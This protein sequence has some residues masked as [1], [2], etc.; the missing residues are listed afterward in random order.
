MTLPDSEARPKIAVAESQDIKEKIYR[1]RYAVYVDEMSKRP[2]YADHSRKFLSDALDES[3][4][5]LYA[6]I[7]GSVVASVRIN[8]LSE[9][10]VDQFLS[11]IYQVP[12]W[13]ESWPAN[14]LSMTS[15]LVLQSNWRGSTVLGQLLLALYAFARE[16]DLHFNFLNCSPGLVEFYEQIGYW[17]FGD[18]FVDPDV[19]YHVP[20]VLPIQDHHHLKE[21]RSFCTR[22]S[23]QLPSTDKGTI[24]FKERFPEYAAHINHRLISPEN[25]WAY[26]AERLHN[27]PERSLQLLNGL[28][29]E[30]A[31]AF[32]DTGTI[33]PCKAGSTL[34]RPGDVG[35][36]MFVILEGV[37]EV[38]SADHSVSLALLGPGEIFGEM[39]FVSKS[40][41]TA[42]VV[43]K[44]DVQVLILTQS[45]LN[46]A[47]K[48]IPEIVAK[49]LLNLSVILVN[50]LR[51]STQSWVDSVTDKDSMGVVEQ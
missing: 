1:L 8:I 35:N 13:L 11:D 7:G 18:G 14:S 30:E 39:A 37:V 2:S 33:L 23:R 46:R 15:R 26:M 36:E 31:R 32:L 17:R 9:S 50:R 24:W 16:K 38:W 5:L 47:S 27:D 6:E 34:I 29:N 43:A 22:L 19:G 45:L 51:I 41:R 40:P 10:P 42:E 28:D 3:G 12:L 21:V 25:F 49:V 48:K 20:M 4:H 44:T